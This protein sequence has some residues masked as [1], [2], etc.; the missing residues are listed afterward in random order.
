ME[1]KYI[2]ILLNLDTGTVDA[3]YNIMQVTHPIFLRV[4]STVC[5]FFFCKR[6][7]YNGVDTLSFHTICDVV[8][9]SYIHFAH[10]HEEN[11][12]NKNLFQGILTM[13]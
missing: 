2:S 5:L 10:V 9:L 4:Q 11:L 12:M 13:F 7:I 6:Y 3:F 8:T 1:L